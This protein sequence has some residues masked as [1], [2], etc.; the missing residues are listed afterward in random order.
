MTAP[1]DDLRE[2]LLRAGIAPRHVRR[3]LAELSDHI[4]DLATEEHIAGRSCADAQ[5]AALQRIGGV[6]AL[7]TAMIG[8]RELQSWSS[9]APWAMFG[10]VPPLLLAGAYLIACLILWSGWS[11]FLPAAD[12]PFG[13]RLHGVAVVYFGLGKLLYFGAPVLLGWGI[14]LIAARQRMGALWPT[15]GLLVTAWLA[16][17]ARVH[18]R[19]PLLPGGVGS[20]SMDLAATRGA[21]LLAILC[22][23]ALPYCIWR[24]LG[25]RSVSAE[26]P[27]S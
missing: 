11:L 20:I 26:P 19:R 21:Q 5:A 8:R 4:A 14:A 10:L 3:Y 18:A 27:G 6:D 23:A 1:F 7:A 12:T 9:R 22:L 17:S 24:L 16:A 25:A 13:P 15:A 2:R